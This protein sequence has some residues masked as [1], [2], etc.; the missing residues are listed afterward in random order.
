VIAGPGYQ[1][2]DTSLTLPFRMNNLA[3]TSYWRD[4]RRQFGP[5][6]VTNNEKTIHIKKFFQQCSKRLIDD[7]DYGKNYWGSNN[8][9][10]GLL[11]EAKK[12][13]YLNCKLISRPIFV[14]SYLAILHLYFSSNPF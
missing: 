11:L 2:L 13:L 6:F 1:P 10:C 7:G 9:K 12:K 8:I 14:N 5:N 4:H 3:L